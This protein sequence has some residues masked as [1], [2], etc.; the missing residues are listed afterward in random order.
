MVAFTLNEEQ[1]ALRSTVEEFAREV[2]AP[3]IGRYYEQG[4]FPYDI[5]ARMGKMG[6]FGLPFPAEYGGMDGDYFAFCLVLHELARVD[7]SVAITSRANSS[8]VPRSA[9]CS[10]LSAKPTM[11]WMLPPPP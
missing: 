7:S 2:V 8:T 9:S 11:P 5:V 4:E 6:L 1:E 10:S 3:V